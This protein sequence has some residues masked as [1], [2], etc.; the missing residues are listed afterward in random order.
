MTELGEEAEAGIRY[1]PLSGAME[2]VIKAKALAHFL[3]TGALLRRSDVCWASYDEYIPGVIA[4][5]N[6]LQRYGRRIKPESVSHA[7]RHAPA[8]CAGRVVP[9]R[10]GLC[11]PSYAAIVMSCSC[12]SVAS[13]G[14]PF[15]FSFALWE[16]PW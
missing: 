2:S 3:R 14:M 9:R 1:G 11:L 12:L 4:F 6:E 13:A 7:L 15:S 8:T 16:S 5:A 10:R